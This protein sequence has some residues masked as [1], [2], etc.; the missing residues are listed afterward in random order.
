[1]SRVKLGD[2]ELSVTAMGL[3]CGQYVSWLKMPVGKSVAQ[4]WGPELEGFRVRGWVAN[5]AEKSRLVGLKAARKP[6]VFQIDDNSYKV[7]CGMFRFEED[8][9]NG[10]LDYELE[11]TEVTRPRTLVF[12]AAAEMKAPRNMDLYL[13]LLRLEA[14]AFWWLGITDRV[15]GWIQE[16]AVQA[17][18]ILDLLGDVVR[19]TE[20]PS[21]VLGQIRQASAVVVTKAESL[22]DLCGEELGK[23]RKYSESE[24]GLKRALVAARQIRIEMAALVKACDVLPKANTRVVVEDGDTLVTLAARWNLEHYADVAWY[25]IAAANGIEDPSEIQEGQELLI[26]NS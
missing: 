22:I 10:E 4:D 3:D 13:A 12:V 23:P 2:I 20:L 25:E 11:L 18:L 5:L 24:E 9:G 14:R 21:A 1:M 7:Q 6:V 15:A 17:V 26:P 16:M 19:L 8:Q